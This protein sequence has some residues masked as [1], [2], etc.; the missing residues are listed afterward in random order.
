VSSAAEAEGI[1]RFW[2][3]DA[4]SSEIFQGNPAAV[5]VMPPSEFHKPTVTQW[6]QSMAKENNLSETAYVA[7][8]PSTGDIVE[9][10]LRWFTPGTFAAANWQ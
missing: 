3:V 9:Y 7:R 2:Q 10:D 4:F 6:M 8:R 5:V 1:L